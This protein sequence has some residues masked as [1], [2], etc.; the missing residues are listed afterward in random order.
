MLRASDLAYLLGCRFVPPILVG[1]D[2][3][4][5]PHSPALGNC[6]RTHAVVASGCANVTEPL[7]SRA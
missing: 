4:G 3:C 1:L 5:R 6:L 2:N 7:G